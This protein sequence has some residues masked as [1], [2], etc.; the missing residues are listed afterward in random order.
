MLSALP[1]S[2]ARYMRSSPHVSTHQ[3]FRQL[4][5][6]PERGSLSNQPRCSCTACV[7]GLL[8]CTGLRTET[9]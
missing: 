7:A 2:L 3:R 5:E 1:S 8:S 4:V 6:R 9:E